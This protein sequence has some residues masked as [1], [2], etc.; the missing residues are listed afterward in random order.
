MSYSS[1]LR[2]TDKRNTLDL[3]ADLG[4]ACVQELSE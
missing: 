1:L 3:V 2:H 4:A